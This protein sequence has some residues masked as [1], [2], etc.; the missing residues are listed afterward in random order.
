[1][2]DKKPRDVA[3]QVDGRDYV[4]HLGLNGL[5][6]LGDELSFARGERFWQDLRDAV[7]DPRCLRTIFY[8]A[9]LAHHADATLEGAGSL[10]D[11]V[12]YPKAVRLACEALDWTTTT[13][14]K[15]ASPAT[16]NLPG[17][18]GRPS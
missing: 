5:A 16:A 6:A 3:F 8:R 13:P 14:A 1:L 9:L 11:S 10:I 18:S 15:S 2:T 12:G 7:T 4:L 17:W